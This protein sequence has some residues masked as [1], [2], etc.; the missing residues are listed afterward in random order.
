MFLSTGRPN[1][2]YVGRIESLW[3]AWGGNMVVRTRW[4]YHPEETRGG[5]KLAEVK[6]YIFFASIFLHIYVN[7]VHKTCFCGTISSL[8]SN[9]VFTIL[10]FIVQGALYQS[11]HVDENDV[12]TISHKCYVLSYTEYRARRAHLN[13][14]N[15]G[16]YYLAGTYEPT[17]GMITFEADVK[18]H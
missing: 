8:S 7:S 13:E 12:Q 3:E 14:D 1:L 6:V 11:P 18:H 4:F 15:S 10:L 5:K 2:P 16:I 17:I 9:Q